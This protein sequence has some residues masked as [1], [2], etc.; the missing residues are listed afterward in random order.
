MTEIIEVHIDLDGKTYRVGTLRTMAKNGRN[1]A[2]FEYHKDWLKNSNRFSIEPS[3]LVGEG[4]FTPADGR[5]MFGCLGDSA[6]DTWGRK[7]MQRRERHSAE[8]ERRTIKTLT[9]ADYLLG[10]ADVARLGAFRFKRA[11]DDEFQTSFQQGS[12]IPPFVNLP[13]LFA[14]TERIL[15]DEETDEDILLLLAPGSSLGGARPKASIRDRDGHLS[16]AKFPKDDDDRSIGGWEEVA[17]RLADMAG[18]TTAQHRLE[19]IAGKDIM[20]SRR[21]D[22]DRD[23]RRIPFLSALSMMG[24]SDGQTGSYPEIVDAMRLYGSYSGMDAPEL[25]RRMIF[26]ILTSNVDD[27][28]R[29]HGFLWTDTKGWKLSPAYDLNPVP[30]DVKPLILST[31]VSLDEATGSIKL[32]LEQAEYFDLKKQQ[33][34]E[35]IMDVVCATSQWKYVASNIGI[36]ESEIKRMKLLLHVRQCNLRMIYF[37]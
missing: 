30:R 20:L 28:L 33:A 31:N 19:R 14:V 8:K 9:E 23:G 36:K 16:I 2:T 22:R 1:S 5:D 4:T 7:L 35:I 26:N 32:A 34:T 25:F 13:K 29:N 3:L 27:H 10:V 15:R 21:F 12:A 11:S 37:T 6:P 17:L 18:I 24:L